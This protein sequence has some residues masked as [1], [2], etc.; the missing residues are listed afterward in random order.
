MEGAERIV[1]EVLGSV[2][3]EVGNPTADGS[4]VDGS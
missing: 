4:G 1:V 3:E 2:A